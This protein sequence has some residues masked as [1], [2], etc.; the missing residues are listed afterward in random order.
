MLSAGRPRR[1]RRRRSSAARARPGESA[2]SNSHRAAD[3]QQ[4]IFRTGINFVRVDVIVTDKSGKPVSDLKQ[5]DFEITEA[6]KPQTIETF[7]LIE[8]DGGLMP[9]PDGPA[10][11]IRT[12]FDEESEAARDDVRLFG[13]FLDDYHTR[14]GSSL[15]ARNE[16]AR[17]VETQLGPSDMIGMMYPLTP[18]DAIR[19]TRNHDAVR[20]GIQQFRGRK[21]DYQAKN[22]LE[23]R[24]V[25]RVSTEQAESIRNDVSLSALKAM[26][27]RMGGLKEGRKALIVVSE[28][29]SAILPPQM[30]NPCACCGGAGNPNSQDPLA[31]ANSPLEDRAAW[32]AGTN[33][34]MDLR[35]VTDLANR[36][37]V[38][39]YMVDPRGLA[40]SEFD[41]SENIGGQ[42]DRGYLNATMDTL[43]TLA[44]DTDGRAIVN[45][46]DLTMAM[47]QIV[48]DTSAYYLLGYNSTFTDPDGKFHEIKVRVKRPGIQVRARRGYWAM[49]RTDAARA[50]A[51][52]NPKPGPPKAVET[53]IAAITPPTRARVIRTWIGTERGA[54]GKTK[55]SFVWEPVPRAPGDSAR[56][57]GTPARVAVTAVSP[58]G[59]PYFRGRVPDQAASPSRVSFDAA[60]GKMQ[61]R[62]SVE[63]AEGQVLDSEIREITVPDL[64][65]QLVIGTPEVFHVRTVREFQQAEGRSSGVAGGQPRVQS[66]RAAAHPADRLR[67]GRDHAEAHRPVAQSRRSAHERASGGRRGLVCVAF[68]DRARAGPDTRRASTSSKSLRAAR[69]AKSKSWLPSA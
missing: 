60:P 14:E 49:T 62:L 45:R 12:E 30:R 35:D 64:T 67:S 57:S 43:R 66:H 68:G 33:M 25:C 51:I 53:A 10:R 23:E 54:D 41:I 40:T 50:E 63:S 34:A 28:G 29:Y 3:P 52:A 37:N 58:E 21:F 4:P 19:F 44:L 15:S 39:L 61:L 8:L 47:K 2:E 59:S 17:F 6:G 22:S 20:R 32:S 31:G 1:R 48:L 13:L 11:Q 56:S 27:V 36:N 7:K 65:S 26:I 38:A 55:V 24:Y 9:G 69:P 16:I 18:L 5:T 46:N 42:I